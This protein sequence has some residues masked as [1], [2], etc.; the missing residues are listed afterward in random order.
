MTLPQKCTKNEKQKAS[1][2]K[3]AKYAKESV[4]RLVFKP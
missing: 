4:N 2:A 1:L 3:L